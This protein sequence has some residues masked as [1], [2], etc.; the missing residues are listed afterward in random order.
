MRDPLDGD[1]RGNGRQQRVIP[2][3]RF[4]D[5]FAAGWVFGVS[6]AF[7][8]ALDIKPTPRI[9]SARSPLLRDLAGLGVV[10]PPDALAG[11]AHALAV[12]AKDM[13]E[14]GVAVAD[15]S[16]TR[17]AKGSARVV[18]TLETE[19]RP[20]VCSFAKGDVM[21]DPPIAHRLPWGEA[22]SVLRRSVQVDEATPARAAEGSETSGDPGE[23]KATLRRYSGGKL[24]AA[25]ALVCS[26]SEFV[27]LLRDGVE[28]GARTPR[29]SA[30]PPHRRPSSR[31]PD[32]PA[33]GTL[34]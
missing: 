19:G 28:S 16:V 17:D 8:D 6:A 26:Q 21:H 1:T 33:Q 9:L 14:A 29:E 11:D 34:L 10:V 12:L 24:V 22:L 4:E 32:G 20:P 2:R 31:G 15:V 30:C 18:I 27:R 23:V 25:E 5:G 7:K 3:T 13:R